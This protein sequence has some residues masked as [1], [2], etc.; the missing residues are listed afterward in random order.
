MG[1]EQE[2]DLEE[3]EVDL[4]QGVVLEQVVVVRG[5]S[6]EKRRGRRLSLQ[7]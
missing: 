1:R 2:V 4:E 5:I 6:V 3:V 7:T